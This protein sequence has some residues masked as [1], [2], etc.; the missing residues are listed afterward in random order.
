MGSTLP[1]I[2]IDV[3]CLLIVFSCENEQYS[4]IETKTGNLSMSKIVLSIRDAI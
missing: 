1:Q 3:D 2:D 4:L